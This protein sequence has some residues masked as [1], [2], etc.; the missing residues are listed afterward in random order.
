MLAAKDSMSFEVVLYERR[1]RA[2]A[3]P[4]LAANFGNIKILPAGSPL[5]LGLG[6]DN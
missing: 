3:L 5:L 4:I 1:K 6:T 2:E